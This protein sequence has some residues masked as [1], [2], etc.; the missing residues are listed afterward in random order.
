[1][2][3]TVLWHAG[4]KDQEKPN[5]F[6]LERLSTLC[7]AVQEQQQESRLGHKMTSER[8]FLSP[9]HRR[10]S[11]VILAR[12]DVNIFK[13]FPP[14]H[15]WVLHYCR[16]GLLT[17][18]HTRALMHKWWTCLFRCVPLKPFQEFLFPFFSFFFPWF[19]T[20]SLLVWHPLTR[21]KGK[22]ELIKY[23]QDVDWERE[24]HPWCE[25]WHVMCSGTTLKK[26]KSPFQSHCRLHWN[27]FAWTSTCILLMTNTKT[28]NFTFHVM[29]LFLLFIVFIFLQMCLCL[30]T[31]FPVVQ[32]QI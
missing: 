10:T 11:H 29:E 27:R 14:L 17:H 31:S 18:V 3:L 32:K 21:L 2:I 22:T 20:N 28:E 25:L 9:C 15:H 23:E 8:C 12:V 13:V 7:V 6:P 26:K 16:Q 24:T 19:M 5:F 4:V 1:M 30:T